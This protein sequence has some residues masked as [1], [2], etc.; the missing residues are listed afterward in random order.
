ME[1]CLDWGLNIRRDARSRL[2]SP[3]KDE[4]PTRHGINLIYQSTI[5]ADLALE[6][7]FSTIAA[8]IAAGTCYSGAFIRKSRSHQGDP[9]PAKHV[10]GG[11]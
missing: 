11:A 7:I 3:L 8:P 4:A 1:V 2:V 5:S 9:L 6:V 10:Q